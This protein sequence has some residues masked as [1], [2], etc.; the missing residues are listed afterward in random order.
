[1]K[2]VDIINVSKTYKDQGKTEVLRGLNLDL[3]RGEFLCVL[4]P[5]GCGKSTLLNIISGLDKDYVGEVVNDKVKRVA[6]VFQNYRESIFPWLRVW[7]NISYPLKIAGM[8]PEERLKKVRKLC[9]EFNIHLPLDTYPYRLSGGQQQLVAILRALITDPDII[10][11]DEPF[12]ALDY[13]TTLF[14]VTKL[15]EIWQKT[16]VA[17]V[18]VSHDIDEAILL[19]ERIVVLSKKPTR[20]VRDFK[21]SIPYPRTTHSMGL[22]E[23]TE[24]K[25]HIADTFIKQTKVII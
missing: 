1:M 25:H 14:M 20:I 11:M 6:F 4:G 16:Q 12:S 15:Q 3:K 10:L 23:F 24:L 8:S 13:E 18:F 19:S 2:L 5:N 21:N 22:P 17:I 9:E 7:E